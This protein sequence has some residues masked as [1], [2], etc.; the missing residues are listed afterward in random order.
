MAFL[1]YNMKRVVS[2]IGIKEIIKRLAAI[3]LLLVSL[4]IIIPLYGLMVASAMVETS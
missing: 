2:I 3:K 4:Y 1:A